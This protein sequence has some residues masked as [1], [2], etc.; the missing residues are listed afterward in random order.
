MTQE[1]DWGLL[2]CQ[3]ILYQLSYRGSPSLFWETDLK[4]NSVTIYVTVSYYI[5]VFKQFGFIFVYG[6]IKCSDFLLYM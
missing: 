5:W 2:H 6:V 4:K 1:L 3:W